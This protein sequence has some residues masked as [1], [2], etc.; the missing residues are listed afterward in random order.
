MSSRMS[1]RMI[2]KTDQNRN[3]ESYNFSQVSVKEETQT[4]IQESDGK[5]RAIVG[6][7]KCA[8]NIY[9]GIKFVLG[10]TTIHHAGDGEF[11]MAFLSKKNI[12][13][14]ETLAAMKEF[15]K[16]GSLD[17]IET[18]WAKMT[19]KNNVVQ[20]TLVENL[21]LLSEGTGKFGFSLN[22]PYLVI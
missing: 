1:S 8:F 20:F 14:E 9:A 7:I 4:L 18:P 22:N 16:N 12:A 6:N 5:E 19:Y 10:N 15:D 2:I 17:S 11:S 13:A 21:R 3:A